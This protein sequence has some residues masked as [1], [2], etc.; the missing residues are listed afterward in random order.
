VSIESIETTFVGGSRVARLSLE[1]TARMMI[2][3]A[4][5]PARSEGPYYLTS[6]AVTF[7]NDLNMFMYNHMKNNKNYSIY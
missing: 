3:L 7:A 4:S 1:E 2:A 6:V 5:A